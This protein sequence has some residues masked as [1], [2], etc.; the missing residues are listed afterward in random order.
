VT[1]DLVYE[2]KLKVMEDW[3][4]IVKLQDQSPFGSQ[5]GGRK[6]GNLDWC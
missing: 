4:S 3:F 6:K 1:V 2:S 5:E